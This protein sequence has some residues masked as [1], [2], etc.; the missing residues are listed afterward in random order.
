ML[1]KAFINMLEEAVGKENAAVVTKA[2]DCPASVSVRLNPPRAYPV[3]EAFAEGSEKVPWSPHGLLL[4]HRPQ[5]T[6]D[7]LFHAGA[8][9]VQDSSA[10]FVGQAFR[11]AVSHIEGRLR[12]LD[13]CAAPGGKTTDIAASLKEEGADYFLVANEVMRQRAA[14]LRD[15]VGLWGDPRVAVTSC[16]PKAFAALPGFFDVIVADVPCSGEGM[17]RKDPEA[18][19]EWSE[20]AVALCEARQRRIIADA[21]PCLREGG[22]LVYSTCTFNKRENDGNVSWIAA[23][24]GA[25]ILSGAS[26][27]ACPVPATENYPGLFKTEN[28]CSLLPGMVKGEGQY[29]A[30]LKKK[31][32]AE[33]RR[34]TEPATFGKKARGA[35]GPGCNAEL[36]GK[37]ADKLSALFSVPVRLFR[38]HETIA[39]IP[40]AVAADVEAISVLRPLMAGTAVGVIKRE[41]LVPDDDLAHCLDLSPEAFNRQEADYTAALKFLHRD[42]VLFQDAPRGLLLITFKGLPLGFVKNLGTR[43]NNL[44]PQSRRIRMD[45]K[46]TESI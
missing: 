5:F 30:V 46:E 2:L 23:E 19:T 4:D 39:A 17:F 8:Y 3:G 12:V 1:D 43:T 24:L 31:G 14:V 9:Y 20:S 36:R 13:L 34:R 41:D 45:I 33:P 35:A 25:E 11:D 44:M 27:G 37:D 15:N 6:L 26:G 21:W 32:E 10:M 40:E 42:P 22:I 29:C 7:P 28:G 18:Q 38:H 16:D